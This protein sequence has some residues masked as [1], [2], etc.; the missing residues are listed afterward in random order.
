MIT[1]LQ[2]SYRCQVQRRAFLEKRRKSVIIQSVWRGVRSRQRVYLL[3]KENT[4]VRI[5]SAYRRHLAEQRYTKLRNA[6]IKIQCLL[7]MRKQVNK[8][9]KLLSERKE[10]DAM[11]T[12]VDLLKHRLEDEKR[13]RLEIEAENSSLQQKL[14]EVRNSSGR[15]D[16]SSACEGEAPHAYQSSA[17]SGKIDRESV[18]DSKLLDDSTRMIDYLRKEVTKGRELVQT[19]SHENENLKAENKKIKDAYTAAGASFAA[20]NQHNKRQSKANLR[21]MSTHAA[22]IKSQE[23]KMKRYKKQVAELKEDLLMQR[24]VY[25]AELKARVQQQDVIIEIINLAKS[26]GTSQDLLERMR[27]MAVD[28]KSSPDNSRRSGSSDIR[29][30]S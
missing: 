27:S 13:A 4:A 6:T 16:S 18:D 30:S 8:Y 24:S 5:Q 22:L 26:G 21:L 25:S 19:L 2:A 10:H 23:E 28:T 29:R 17:R 7:K 14:K 15:S 11:E 12:E 20:L 9:R 3:M 1:K